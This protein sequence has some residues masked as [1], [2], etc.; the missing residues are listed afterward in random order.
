MN[1]AFV[2]R[3]LIKST[4]LAFSKVKR[5]KQKENCELTFQIFALN[6]CYVSIKTKKKSLPDVLTKLSNTLKQNFNLSRRFW[7]FS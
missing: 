7:K 4:V 6:L 5:R 1:G 3:K 2:N